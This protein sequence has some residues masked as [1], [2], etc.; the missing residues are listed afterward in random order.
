MI[1]KNFPEKQG[2]KYKD[3]NISL[4]QT[5]GYTDN[6]SNPEASLTTSY[7]ETSRIIQGLKKFM[8]DTEISNKHETTKEAT[9]TG[10]SRLF[11]KFKTPYCTIELNSEGS[12]KLEGAKLSGD[13][14]KNFRKK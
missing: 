5:I 2:Y 6:S 14:N 9:P 4:H 10:Q 11:E 1:S 3:L 13:W 8:A 12:K 7:P